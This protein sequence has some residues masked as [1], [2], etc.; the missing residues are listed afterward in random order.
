M[1]EAFE[2]EC[3]FQYTKNHNHQGLKDAAAIAQKSLR[4][5]M[6]RDNTMCLGQPEL[7]IQPIIEE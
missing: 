4:D 3:F 2:D 6:V 5:A 1:L 7:F